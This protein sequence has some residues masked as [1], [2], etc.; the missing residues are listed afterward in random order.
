MHLNSFYTSGGAPNV[1]IVKTTKNGSNFIT[2]KTI[3]DWNGLPNTITLKHIQTA[4]P[5]L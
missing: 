1:P 5:L 2:V 3:K 4:Q